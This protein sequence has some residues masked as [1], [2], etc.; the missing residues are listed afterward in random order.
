MAGFKNF[1]QWK[2]EVE[3]MGSVTSKTIRAALPE[4][5]EYAKQAI[6][7][8]LPPGDDGRFPGYAAKGNL[9]SAIVVSKV[10]GGQNSPTITVG[11]AKNT[12][13]LNLI[14]AFVHEYG[15]TIHA[16]RFIYMTFKIKGKWVRAKQVT[17]RPKHF[18]RDAWEETAQK[19]PVIVEQ[20]L[21]QNLFR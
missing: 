3:L 11:L 8:R 14:K 12:S 10:T 2:R 7:R 6:Q 9:K 17:I 16:R 5:G 15:M 1:D 19:F 20:F 4:V 18:F 21:R 13:Q